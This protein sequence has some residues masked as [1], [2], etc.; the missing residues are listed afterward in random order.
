MKDLMVA[1]PPIED[2]DEA[3][4]P[5]RSVEGLEPLLTSLGLDIYLDAAR[6]FCLLEGVVRCKA[7]IPRGSVSAFILLHLHPPI[8]A[9]PSC[10]LCRITCP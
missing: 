1:P 2:N 6:A 3:S 7:S 8:F 4:S 10:P 9:A 5:S